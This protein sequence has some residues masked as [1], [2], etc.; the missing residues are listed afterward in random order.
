MDLLLCLFYYYYVKLMSIFSLKQHKTR[1]KQ[2][3][4]IMEFRQQIKV[5]KKK[6]KYSSR[7]QTNQKFSAILSNFKSSRPLQN[8]AQI[9]V[10]IQRIKQF[11]AI[12]SKATIQ[13][14][15]YKS[16][17]TVQNKAENEIKKEQLDKQYQIPAILKKTLTSCNINLKKKKILKQQSYSNPENMCL[18]DHSICNVHKNQV[19]MQKKIY[20]YIIIQT[21]TE[22]PHQSDRYYASRSNRSDY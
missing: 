1:M 6:R 15:I 4:T 5:V 7:N 18:L 13:N 14:E 16:S 11:Y 21:N 20:F 12:Y 3:N 2:Q 8:F 17:T 10:I 19:S 9:Y 22:N